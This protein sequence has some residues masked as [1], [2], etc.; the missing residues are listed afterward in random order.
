MEILNLRGAAKGTGATALAGARRARFVSAADIKRA[1]VGAQGLPAGAWKTGAAAQLVVEV[2]GL[3]EVVAALRGELTNQTIVLFYRT[4]G[5]NYQRTVRYCTAVG[6]SESRFPP[7]EGS[8]RTPL[9][10]ITFALHAGVGI[11]TWAQAIVTTAGGEPPVGTSEPLVRLL[12][13]TRNGTALA[14]AVQAALRGEF[15][16]TTGRRNVNGVP[17]GVWGNVTAIRVMIE[18]EDEASW[19][20]ALQTAPGDEILQLSFQAGA[21]NRT[22]RCEVARLVDPGQE[23]IRS[24]EE[25]QTPT[26]T[27]LVWDL[28]TGGSVAGPVQ[29]L[30]LT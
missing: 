22:L 17:V 16:V 21:S 8:G 20:S 25:A 11:E 27:Q 26:R 14:G 13:A 28:V 30:T 2:E 9:S 18:M 3:A 1:G 29:A 5:G 23:E 4:A 12:A 10:E 7:A 24:A 15:T 19:L 6:V